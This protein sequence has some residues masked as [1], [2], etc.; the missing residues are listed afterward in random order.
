MLVR[1]VLKRIHKEGCKSVATPEA[2]KPN[3]SDSLQPYRDLVGALKYLVL[4]SRPRL[5]MLCAI[6]ASACPALTIFHYAMAKRVLRYL[7]GTAS[8]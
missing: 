5:R 3:K 2:T 4:A 7:A 6:S 1:E 8:L